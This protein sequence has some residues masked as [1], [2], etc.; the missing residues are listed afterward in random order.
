MIS[1]GQKLRRARPGQARLG[2]LL[3]L[4]SCGSMGWVTDFFVHTQNDIL[5]CYGV[6]IVVFVWFVVVQFPE[7]EET[8]NI[9]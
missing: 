3:Q 6:S 7:E 4:G 8:D 2:T 5:S 1:A 9:V